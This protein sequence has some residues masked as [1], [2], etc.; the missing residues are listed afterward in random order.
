VRE[1]IGKCAKQTQ[2]TSNPSQSLL[3]SISP[4]EIQPLASCSDIKGPLTLAPAS[5]DMIGRSQ[6]C[7]LAA[8]ALNLP[9]AQTPQASALEREMHTQKHDFFDMAKCESLQTSLFIYHP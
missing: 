3:Y 9:S 7:S 5:P 4:Q 2:R 8:D 1:K 6:I